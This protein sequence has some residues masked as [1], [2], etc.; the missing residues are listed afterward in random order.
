MESIDAAL[1]Q[2]L[3]NGQKHIQLCR[4]MS[5][6]LTQYFNGMKDAKVRMMEAAAEASVYVDDLDAAKKAKDKTKIKDLQ[7]KIKDLESKYEACIDEYEEIQ[8]D[9]VGEMESVDASAETVR[10]VIK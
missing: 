2:S 7:K 1:K 6:R 10:P 4:Q 8:A 5:P 3:A 9:M